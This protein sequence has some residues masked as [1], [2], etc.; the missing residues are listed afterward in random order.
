MCGLRATI[1]CPRIV[2]GRSDLPWVI[3]RAAHHSLR[4]GTIGRIRT[5]TVLSKTGLG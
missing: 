2:V 3:R 1:S 4:C 5:E